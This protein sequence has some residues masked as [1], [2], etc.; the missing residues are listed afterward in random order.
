MSSPSL[1]RLLTVFMIGPRD[2]EILRSAGHALNVTLPTVLEAM[3]QKAEAGSSLTAAVRNPAVKE[4]RSIY[5]ACITTGRLDEEFASVARRLGYAYCEHGVPTQPL[6]IGHSTTMIAILAERGPIEKIGFGRSLFS[7]KRVWRAY[8]QRA[9]YSAAFSKATWLGLSM[10]LDG[11]GAAEA[12]RRDR[13]VDQLEKHFNLRIGGPLDAMTNGSQQLDV[14][15]QSMSDSAIRSAENA[16]TIAGAADHASS[17]VSLV[18]AAAAE[19]AASVMDVSGHVSHSARLASKAV[20]MAQRT[21][22]V[23]KALA[24]SARKVGDVVKLISSIAG[25]TNLL[26]LNATIEASRAGDAG[27]GFAVVAS[28]VKNLANQTARAT[29]DISLQIGQIQL[30]TNEAVAAID[31][32]SRAI[33]EVSQVAEV[34]SQAIFNQNATVDAITHSVDRAADENQ[35]VSHLMGSVR[36]DSEATVRIA[37]NLTSI[38]AELGSQSS[39][40]RRVAQSFLQDTRAA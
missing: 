35:K 3:H 23:V 17:T 9:R 38:T 8:H 39:A 13:A 33:D 5:W 30:A 18:A 37:E 31:E 11:Y 21:D 24:N 6:T 2:L 28:E 10:V 27:R 29:A 20:G 26:A 19:L 32:I 22:S 12:A 7:R 14:A 25:Q 1:H 4:L 34:I 15:V 36:G 40:L 16:D